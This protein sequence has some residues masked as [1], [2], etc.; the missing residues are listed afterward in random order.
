M[1]G[2][3]MIQIRKA[4]IEDIP[5]IT[6]L[7]KE[8]IETIN[9]KDYNEEQVKVWSAGYAYTDRWVKRLYTQYFIVA[10]VDEVI[11]GIGS[12]DP[13]GYLDIMYVHK[14][15]QGRGVASAL[16][17][18]LLTNAVSNNVAAV[19]SD[20]SITAKPFFERNGFIT[21]ARQEIMI[22]NVYLTNYKMKLRFNG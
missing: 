15:Y 22:N 13:D 10:I 5:S 12:I 21:E 4:T 11:A 20:V 3:K 7:F 17:D 14:D 2:K 6:Q 8:T 16:I 9:S 18:E 1:P 19:T